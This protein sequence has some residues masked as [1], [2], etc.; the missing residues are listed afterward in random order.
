M[1]VAFLGKCGAGKS[2]LI[3]A[4]FGL[5][6][7]TGSYQATTLSLQRVQASLINPGDGSSIGI[8]I[9]DTPGFAE[10]QETKDEYLE[11]Y[12][13][14]LP[15]IDHLVW[16]VQSHPRT[17]RPDQEALLDLTPAIHSS[18]TM[19]VALT[20]ADTIGPNNWDHHAGQPSAEQL[21]ALTEQADNVLSKLMPYAPWLTRHD[22]VPCSTTKGY[23]LSAVSERIW[24]AL[25]A[26]QGTG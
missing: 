1:R 20:R 19:T 26:R 17:F 14:L 3:N 25:V 2:S 7:R 5:N 23:G 9:V 18:L 12:A 10:S 16:V 24:D 22:I 11:A 21:Q 4:L 15:T 13:G 6:L 8:E